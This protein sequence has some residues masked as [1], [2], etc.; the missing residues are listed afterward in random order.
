MRKPFTF[1]IGLLFLF[2]SAHAQQLSETLKTNPNVMVGKLSNG[3]T[4]YIQK[5][6]EP[7]NRVEL[8]LVIDAGSICENDDQ[9][10]LA[11]LLEHMCFNGTKHFE[12]QALVNFIESTGVK[13]GAHLNAST[14]FD[15][16]IYMLQ[17]PTDR[18][19]LIDSAMLVLEDWAHNVRLEADEI[20]KE[21][22]VVK[23]EWRLGLGANDRM[24]QKYIP[25]MLKGSRYAE[26]L[27]IGKIPVIDT[28][29]YATI[30]SFYHTWYRPDL[31]AVIVVGDID[32]GQIKKE[33]EK[34][35]DKLT[36]PKEE[37]KRVVYGVPN[38]KKPLIAIET[39]KEATNNLLQV[40]YK[41][42]RKVGNTVGYFRD[43][44]MASLY[45]S[46][47]NARLGE[48]T[49]KPTAPFMYAFA[50]YGSFIGRT[51]NAYTDI[52]VCK[53]NQIL[54]SLKVFLNEDKRVKDY[55]F[56]QTEL[57]RQ[58][59]NLLRRYEQ[60]Y[61]ERNKMSSSRLTREYI[62]NFLTKEPIPGITEEYD[63]AKKLIPEISLKEVNALTGKWIT[64]SN[65]VVLITAPQ[66]EGV[67]V[68]TKDEVL[69][70][71]RDEANVTVKPYVDKVLNAPLIDHKITPGKIVDVQHNDQ[72]DKWTLNNGMEVFIKPTNFKN[73]QVL[74]RAY[75]LGGTSLL[76]DDKVIM[77]RVFNNIVD[78]SG[79]GKFSDVELQKKLSGKVASLSP[80]FDLLTQGYS[81][82]AS[83]RDLETLLKLQYLFF[84]QPRQDQSI[85]EKVIDDA[86][87]QIKHVSANPKMVFY[88]SLYKVVTEHSPRVIV[89]PTE[90]QINS[91]W[92][93][94][95]YKVYKDQFQHAAGYK[96]F[97]VGN[98]NEEALKPLVEKYLAS[99]PAGEALHWKDVT[100]GFPKGENKVTVHKGSEP[101]SS[102][103]LMMKGK[104][105]YN[106]HNNLLMTALVQSLNIE[107]REKVREQE[108]GTYG[109]Y[110]YPS[111]DKYP[112]EQYSLT[113]NFGCAPK[114]VDKLVGSVFE[115]FEKFKKEGPTEATL[116]KV[117]ETFIR[118]RESDGRKNSFWLNQIISAQFEGDA[119]QSGAQ[120]DAAV[121]AISVGE[122]KKFARK[123]LTT[124]HY[125]LGVLK[126]E[127]DQKG[128]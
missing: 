116:K 50:G 57:E 68:P 63:L 99:I 37:V 121:K 119:I 48:I 21:R 32:P 8:R 105:N 87:N 106:E 56:T 124:D 41:S 54:N 22:G 76:P 91:I 14:S 29:H 51:E 38:N 35:F 45:N 69:Q 117:K 3:L 86:K 123:Y 34:H 2:I 6:E 65:M 66:K 26:R 16:T 110:M 36:N 47:M 10:G 28:A 40:F 17:M 78:Q 39:D 27:P 1:F 111:L 24:M 109:I 67:K 80:N 42:P 77:T 53:D 9:Q 12:K 61:A 70:T 107:L 46:M 7:K 79:L 33:I 90:K 101:Q 98:V 83:P 52:A 20:D 73:D 43:Q 94:Q 97:F 30:R 23:E 72:Y 100:P 13:F 104:Y 114:N 5:N 103:I 108:S 88:D 25:I 102:V 60:Q 92:Q 95:I 122:L 75:S 58:K 96:V 125:V 118:T 89:V 81:G 31:M 71:I 93:S 19:S 84:T 11:H 18:A 120:Y 127:T 55:G 4:Y 44:L 59:Q 15:Q 128:N 82:S 115:I 85:F 62:N 126:P 112:Q 74:Y 49:K 64:D 113:L